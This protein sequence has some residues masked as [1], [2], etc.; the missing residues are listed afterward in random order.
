[1]PLRVA[2]SSAAE[3]RWADLGVHSEVAHLAG[4]QVAVLPPG[5]Q[6][7]NL[8]ARGERCYR[9]PTAISPV[10][11]HDDLLALFCSKRLG[12]RQRLDGLLRLRDRSRLQRAGSRPC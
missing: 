1:M 4:D 2:A 3:F 10:A 11:L 12:L 9:G 8:C 7:G 6:D 5:V